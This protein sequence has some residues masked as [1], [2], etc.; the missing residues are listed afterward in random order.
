MLR[1][2]T[3]LTLFWIFYYVSAQSGWQNAIFQP[4]IKS[5][6]VICNDNFTSPPLILLN[7]DQF[8]S[9][10]FDE[11]TNDMSWISY[12]I[13]HC[14]AN[15]QRSHLSELEYLNGFN[16]VA[17]EDVQPSFNTFTSY[18]HYHITLPNENIQFRKSGNYAVLFFRDDQPDDIIASACFSVFERETSVYANVTSNTDISLNGEYQQVEIRLQ[19]RNPVLSNPADELKVVVSQN[20]RR[21]NEVIVNHP[22]RFSANEAFFEHNR[23]LIFEAGNNFRRFEIVDHKYAG[24]GVEQIRYFEPFYHVL[25]TP[26]I[27]RAQQPYYYDRDQNGKYIIRKSDAEINETEADYFMVHFCLE[28]ENPFIEGSIHLA[29]DFTYNRFTDE[30]KLI[31][32]FEQRR[33][34]AALLLKQGH[35]NYQYLFLPRN[36]TKASPALMEGNFHETENEY[37]IKVYHRPPGQRYDRLIG[38]SL[39]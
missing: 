28:E 6:Q 20:N 7:S 29:G 34:E 36:G 5:L 12:R 31:Y 30:T 33:Y 2:K 14:D 38:Y 1:I 19:W 21:D 18:Y 3:F 39:I 26:S 17:V 23:S 37:L 22:N 32:N 11:L 16:Q 10:S 15:W 9:I 13:I 25:L 8:V 35:Y 27:S 4:A 24:I